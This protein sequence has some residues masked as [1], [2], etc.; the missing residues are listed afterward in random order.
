MSNE[1]LVEELVKDEELLKTIAN[2]LQENPEE[3]AELLEQ[4]K[5]VD[6][7][8]KKLIALDKKFSIGNDVTI[9][10]SLA[11]GTLSGF[12]IAGPVGGIIGVLAAAVLM[13]AAL[14][15]NRGEIKE[16]AKNV[17]QDFQDMWKGIGQSLENFINKLLT[18]FFTCRTASFR[19]CK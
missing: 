10:L 18:R 2:H 11:T 5:K 9:L 15:L 13:F 14:F 6:G 19:C 16:S 8:E 3:L 12:A 4:A 7:M 17:Q 1:E